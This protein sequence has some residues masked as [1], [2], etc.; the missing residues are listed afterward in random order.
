MQLMNT[1]LNCNFPPLTTSF[2]DV[3]ASLSEPLHIYDFSYLEEDRQAQAV[4]AAS[5]SRL[6][7]LTVFGGPIGNRYELPRYDKEMEN[8]YRI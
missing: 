6:P 5:Y 7:N 2:G 8:F 1:V 3:F 4:V